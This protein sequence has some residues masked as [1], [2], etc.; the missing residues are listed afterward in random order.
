MWVCLVLGNICHR[1]IFANTR[2][3]LTHSLT[4]TN[5]SETQEPRKLRFLIEKRSLKRTNMFATGSVKKIKEYIK[6]I[7]D[8]LN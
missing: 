3:A 2:Y 4:V 7:G 1:G 8:T 5:Y 6:A